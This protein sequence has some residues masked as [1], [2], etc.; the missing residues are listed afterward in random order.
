[1][2]KLWIL[3]QAI[4]FENCPCIFGQ[5]TQNNFFHFFSGETDWNSQ[6]SVLFQGDTVEERQSECHF[7]APQTTTLL[8]GQ[9]ELCF[10]DTS[11]K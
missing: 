6:G 5:Q 2:T 11:G 8:K 10:L 4:T 1:M 9:P 3:I 7:L